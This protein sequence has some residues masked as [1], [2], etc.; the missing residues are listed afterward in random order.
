M[1]DPRLERI[2]QLMQE[3]EDKKSGASKTKTS[4]GD[5]A[6]YRF[7]DIKKDTTA[8]VRFLPDADD[9]NPW[10]WVEKQTITLEFSGVSGGE[11]P[12]DELV[13][14]QVPCIDM[15]E[16]K[17]C[18]I[19]K[20]TKYLWSDKTN[21]ANIA[22][23]KKYYKARSFIAQGFV[24]HSP[25]EEENVPENPIRRLILGPQIVK[26]LK[27]GMADPD[28]DYFPTDY[29]NGYDFR[30]K[31]TMTGDGRNNDYNSSSLALRSRALTEDE[32]AA[33]DK[34]KLFNLA[35][36]RGARPDADGVAAIKAMFEASFAGE[37]YDWDSFSK[38][39]WRPF[40]K[41]DATSSVTST[42][43]H[44]E[45]EDDEPEPVKVEVKA[46]KPASLDVI[47]RLRE[48]NAATR[49]A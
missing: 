19:I 32:M 21:T 14:V 27:A 3:E 2:R 46:S 16:D 12:S 44:R 13:K 48:K 45:T 37:P 29:M 28:R 38:Y 24:V 34:Y 33:I 41:R 4:Y 18:P 15:Y 43:S 11:Y 5:N 10:F 1:A 25:F 7:W 8:T 39:G 22:I 47:S 42:V 30:I 23:A 17:T 49:S 40:T 36:Y 35:D 26:I 20:A 31:K 6:S 9:N